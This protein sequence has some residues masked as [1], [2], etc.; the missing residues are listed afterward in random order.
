MRVTFLG[1]GTSYGVPRLGCTCDVCR[2]EDP[3]NKR[4]RASVLV[5]TDEGRQVLVDTTPDLRMQLLDAGVTH[6]DLVVNTHFHA[7]HVFGLDDLRGLTDGR[8]SALPVLIPPGTERLFRSTFGYVFDR[9][10]RRYGIPWLRLAT[11]HDGVLSREAEVEVL[12]IPVPHGAGITR[13]LRFGS[14]AYL[15]DCHDV[16][17][18]ARAALEGL[19][20]LVLDML[21][22]SPAPTHLHLER[23]L[24]LAGLIGARRTFFIHMSHAVDHGA[25]EAGL[26]PGILLGYDGLV[27]EV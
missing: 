20:L 15:T 7:D 5:E 24:E 6:L 17:P 9:T 21:R 14:F 26:P 27:V 13:G 1:S 23:S 11:M 10:E 8:S 4:R 22:P 2:S 12:P 19:D 18:E 16:P 25:V 3:R